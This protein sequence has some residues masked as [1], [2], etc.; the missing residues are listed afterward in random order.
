MFN[1]WPGG[2]RAG[3][4]QQRHVKIKGAA[5]PFDP[6]WDEYF[7]NR[8]KKQVQ[9]VT[10]GLMAKV[11]SVQDGVCPVFEQVIQY[12]EELV[13][14]HRDGKRKNLKLANWFF[15][16]QTATNRCIIMK[17]DSKTKPSCPVGHLSCLS[18]IR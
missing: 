17:P 8:D 13:L 14:H 10:A 7:E 6:E 18:S 15:F 9:A 3:F 5:N 4:K 16:T 11:H 12:D 2:S 1:C